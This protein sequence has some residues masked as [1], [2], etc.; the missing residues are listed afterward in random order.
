MLYPVNQQVPEPVLHQQFR[1]AVHTVAAHLTGDALI[2]YG[3]A[4]QLFEDGRVVIVITGA[5]AVGEAVAEG[6][7]HT[8]SW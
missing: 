1:E 6:Q 8:V 3:A 2:D 5:G 4:T 7:D